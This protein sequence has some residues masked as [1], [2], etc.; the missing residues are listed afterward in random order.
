MTSE[1]EVRFYE[2]A[3]QRIRFNWSTEVSSV[4]GPPGKPSHAA[5]KAT[6]GGHFTWLAT[7]RLSQAGM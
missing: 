2:E 7:Q 6:R 4:M 5:W 1:V 3:P